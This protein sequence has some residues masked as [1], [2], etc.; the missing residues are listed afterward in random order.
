MPAVYGRI[1]IRLVSPAL[2]LKNF[3]PLGRLSAVRSPVFYWS[4]QRRAEL[5]QEAA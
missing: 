5:Q 3:A 1:L 2:G 4:A